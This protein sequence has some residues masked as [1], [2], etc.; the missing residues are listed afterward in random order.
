[1]KLG[2]SKR[3]NQARLSLLEKFGLGL[4]GLYQPEGLKSTKDDLIA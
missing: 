4:T 3:T 1:M 2:A